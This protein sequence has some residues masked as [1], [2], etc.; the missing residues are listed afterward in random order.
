M[1][2]WGN[3]KTDK[4]IKWINDVYV[5][6]VKSF[7]T[8][9]FIKQIEPFGGGLVVF[10]RDNYWRFETRV[11]ADFWM[12]E[13]ERR[14]GLLATTVAE[15]YG[16][17]GKVIRLLYQPDLIYALTLGKNNALKKKLIDLRRKD[18]KYGQRRKA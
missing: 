17:K 2:A 1:S 3:F 10:S 16:P 9:D 4:L 6:R 18:K 11:L 14:Y 13:I 12:E 8:K 15:H 7:P 5:A